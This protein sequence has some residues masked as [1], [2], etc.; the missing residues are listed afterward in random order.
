MV[1]INL[2]VYFSC[3]AE[4]KM[5]YYLKQ[6]DKSELSYIEDDDK[7]WVKFMPCYRVKLFFFFLLKYHIAA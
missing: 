7:I 4:I 2:N 5:R 1:V 3:G 6:E